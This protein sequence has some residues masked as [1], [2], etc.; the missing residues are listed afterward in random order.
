MPQ[1]PDSS[2]FPL[3]DK[4]HTHTNTHAQQQSPVNSLTLIV[5]SCR[6]WCFVCLLAG[7]RTFQ[8]SSAS[9]CIYQSPILKL[10]E[11]QSKALNQHKT[12]EK[13]LARQE[14]EAFSS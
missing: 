1:V 10:S 4:A 13:R 3:L 2:E 9:A 8:L 6:R 14:S 11:R 7:E 5:V 12:N